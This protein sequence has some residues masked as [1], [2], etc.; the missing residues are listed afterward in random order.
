MNFDLEFDERA[1]LLQGLVKELEDYY[2][3]TR[4][5][6]ATPN[7]NLLKIRSFINQNDFSNPG[8]FSQAIDHVLEGLINYAVHTP[9]PKYF[10]LYNPRACFPG[11]LADLITATF[12][13]Q[14]AAW[15]HAP[16][17]NEVE[18]KLI[19][20][21]GLRF[22]F[23]ADSID[24]VF[25]SGGAEANHSAVLCALNQA[26][27]DLPKDGILGIGKRP[28][29]YCSEETHHSIHK[30]TNSAGLG[31]T[32]VRKIPVNKDM[33]INLSLLEETIIEDI[34]KDL[35]PFMVIGTAGTTGTG[36][37]DDLKQI[38]SI[39]VKYNLW[40]HCDAAYGGAAILSDHLKSYISGIDHADSITFDAHKWMS[41]PMGTSLFITSH[42]EILSKTFGFATEYMPTEA[43]EMDIVDPYSHSIQW[44]RRFIGLRLYLSMLFFGWDGYQKIVDHQ[45]KMGEYLRQKLISNQWS[46]KNISP[47]PVIC[48]TD[49]RFENDLKFSQ[50]ILQSILSSGKSWISVYPMHQVQCFRACITNYSTNEND[51]N[52]LV[53]ELNLH[54]KEYMNNVN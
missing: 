30:A 18:A 26:F 21:F 35:Y 28:M 3:N 47:F 4:Q 16:F 33:Q 48:F 52:E 27:P 45:A 20:E 6:R 17:A 15:S 5:V 14:L 36:T 54:R 22:G 7:L 53:E 1:K 9:H 34:S 49:T 2:T 12:N 42:K 8:N 51:L 40:F 46:V 43:K 39:A 10:G 25:T 13:P 32:S 41:L 50:N 19:K 11:I 24:G 31:Q 29:I 44:S 37:I 23:P 38:K